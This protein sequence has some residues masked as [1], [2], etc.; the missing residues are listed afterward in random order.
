MDTNANAHASD[1]EEIPL[2]SENQL[3]GQQQ[4][5]TDSMKSTC[6]SSL[7]SH[8]GAN[9]RR[10][11]R[12]KSL[13]PQPGPVSGSSAVQDA[14]VALDTPSASQPEG[15][16][17]V[18]PASSSSQMSGSSFRWAASPVDHSLKSSVSSPNHKSDWNQIRGLMLQALDH[19]SKADNHGSS[20]AGQEHGVIIS[21]DMED[22]EEGGLQ[23]EED[24][25]WMESTGGARAFI[26]KA[27]LVFG[28]WSKTPYG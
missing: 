23:C 18:Q 6:S 1:D 24:D 10:G 7:Q 19:A 9:R 17:H 11:R 27:G 4:R 26:G 16:V 3:C 15:H 8:A 21:M 14:P 22:D 12:R 13:Q 20:E 28:F 25:L 2:A 5:T